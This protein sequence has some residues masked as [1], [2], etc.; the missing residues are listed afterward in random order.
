MNIFLTS[1][2]GGIRKENG[3]KKAEKF[4]N[5]NNFL[6][7]LK[8]SLRE[9]KKF[10]LVSSNPEAI[11]QNSKYLE[12]DVI[13]LNMSG[14][15]FD[16]Y[17]VLDNRNK[18]NVKE[19]LKDSSLIMLCG[20]NTYRQNQFFNEIDLKKY[21]LT[22]DTT[23]VGISAGSINAA[24]I[25]YNSPECEED[26]L[27]PELLSGLGLTNINIEPHFDVNN[28]NKMQMDSILSQSYK[29]VIYGLPDGSYIKNNTLYGEGYKIHNGEIKLIC[30][31]DEK[32]KICD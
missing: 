14:I 15:F 1:N 18:D 4:S 17:A 7:M 20:G 11:E 21:I 22:L 12:L 3:E 30:N 27:N 32:Y 25:A 28:N 31:N 10:V 29:R 24:S 13:A 5:E 6:E 2:C 19:I 9:N 23:I 16:E 8:E 26:T